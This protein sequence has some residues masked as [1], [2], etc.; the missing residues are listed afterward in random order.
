MVS[1]LYT[2]DL[3]VSIRAALDGHA[4]RRPRETAVADAT[5]ELTFSRLWRHARS[6]A[7]ATGPLQGRIVPIPATSTASFIVAVTATW[8]AGGVPMPL[9]PKLPPSLRDTMAR[10]ASLGAHTCAPW[11]AVLSIAGGT[12]RPLITGGEPP[13]VARKAHAL[14]LDSGAAL[15]ASPMY[16]NGPFEFA[17]RHLLL[18]GTVVM[19]DR[20]DTTQW[21]HVAAT[22]E[23]TW[24]FLAPIQLQRLLDDLPPRALRTAL[25]GTRTA[26]HSSSPCPPGL[27]DRLLNLVDPHVVAEF[28]GAAEYDG[29][30]ARADEPELGAAPIPGADLRVVDG[31]RQP[32]PP[33]EIGV[34]EGRSTAGLTT[35]YAGEPCA[36]PDLWRTVGDRGSLGSNGRLTVCDVTTTGRAIVGGINVGLTRIH[37]V[38]AAHPAVA[39]CTVTPLAHAEYGQ[40]ITVRVTVR[41]PLTGQ[42]LIDYCT[43]RLRP[44]ERPHKIHIAEPGQNRT[45]EGMPDAAAM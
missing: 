21:A 40:V 45:R 1:S 22:T 14:S 24:T 16:L 37:A 42:A 8:L 33:G 28:Y 11:K 32:V 15:F 38:I 3:V 18:G 26:V 41:E 2:S 27:R 13:T 43:A 39:S 31:D 17:L 5:G 20:F 25:A 44:A 30:L 9:D 19:L 10:R 35:H 12:Y 4:V 23:P 29:T 6:Q 34:I 36:G 7:E